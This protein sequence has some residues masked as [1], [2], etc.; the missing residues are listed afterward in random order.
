MKRYLFNILLAIDQFLNV[1]L[2][3]DPDETISSRV[4][5]KHPWAAR[6]VDRLFWFDPRHTERSAEPDEGAQGLNASDRLELLCWAF[7]VVLALATFVAA[8]AIF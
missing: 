1:L 5:K 2:L 8:W 6:I 7:C 3:G 4:G